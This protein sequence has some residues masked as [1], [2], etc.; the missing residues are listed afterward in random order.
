MSEPCAPQ[1]KAFQ[2]RDAVGAKTEEG[3]CL[4]SPKAS[5]EAWMVG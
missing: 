1:G 5:K 3:M 4:A 2:A